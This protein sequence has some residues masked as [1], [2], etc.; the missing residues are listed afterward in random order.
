MSRAKF[1]QYGQRAEVVLNFFKD[2][3]KKIRSGRANVSLVDTIQINAYGQRQDLKNLCNINIVDA[4]LITLQPWDKTIAADIIKGIQEANIGINP[5]SD[6]SLIRLP[7]PQL[8]EERRKEFVKIM[9][10]KVE[11]T[12]ISVRNLRKDIMVGLE[13][14]KNEGEMPEDEYHRIQKKLQELVDET[15]KEVDEIANAKEAELL[16]V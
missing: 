6:G 13:V 16:T 9:K 8:T 7:L 2:E 11:E 15:N 1:E 12:K 3:L 4:N 5:S 10:L 14:Q